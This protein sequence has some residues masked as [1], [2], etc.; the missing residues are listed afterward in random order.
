MNYSFLKGKFTELEFE[1]AIIELFK[2]ENY[3]YVNGDSLHRKFEDILLIDDLRSYLTSRYQSA[4]LSDAEMQKIINKLSLINPTPLYLGNREAFRLV[5]EGFDLVRDDISKVALHIDYIKFDEPD[6]NIFKVINQYSV[7]GERLR[8]PDMLLFINGIPVAILEFKTAIEEDTTIYD[9]WKQITIR[10]CRDIPKLMKYCFLSVISDGA[11]TRMGS[12]FTP[13]EYYYAWNKANDTDTVANGINS[14]FTMIKGAFTKDRII[15]LLRDFIFYPD[16]SPK[17]EAIVCRYPQ[18]FG[19]K[20]MFE[21]IKLHMRP[22]DDGKG[23]TYFGATGCGKTYTMLFLSRLVL[24]RDNEKFNN[25]TIVIIADRE[26]LDTQTS[27]LFVTAKK[28]LHEEDVRSIESREDLAI[29][30]CDRPS[31]GI[32]ITT[33]QKFCENTGLLSDR[34]NIICISDETHRTQTGIGSKLK[35]TDKGVFTTYGFAHYLRTSFPNATYCGFT[36]TPIDETIAVFGDVVESYTMKESS[37]DGITVRIAYE[38]R[39]ARVIISDEQAKEIQKYYDRCADQGSTAEQIEESKKAMSKM[40]KILGNPDR[41]HK[42]AV[43]I[44]DHY[45]ALCAE[46]PDTTRGAYGKRAILRCF[47]MICNYSLK[48]QIGCCSFTLQQPIYSLSQIIK[49][50]PYIFFPHFHCR[51]YRTH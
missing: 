45:D 28:Y 25:P 14:L 40:R 9:A 39:L 8:R 19:A 16:D 30:L 35:K 51:K 27:E 36:G 37:D 50:Y 38:P 22:N 31:G 33:I 6:K 1:A 5:N 42:L 34:S 29:T 10:Y 2:Q 32:Y 48:I 46:N 41:L 3:I 7:Q 20:K 12:I 26:D 21:N 4:R 23:G 13:Y 24:Q 17:N 44:A 18:F 11:N 15:A 49:T 43:D 47:I